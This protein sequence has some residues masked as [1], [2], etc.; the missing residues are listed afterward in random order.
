[1]LPILPKPYPGEALYSVYA[2]YKKWLGYKTDADVCEDLFGS[3]RAKVSILLPNDLT[4]LM[5][6]GDM[7]QA[8]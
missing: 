6:V 2:R 8:R 3:R 4:P 1:M 7:F 5:Q